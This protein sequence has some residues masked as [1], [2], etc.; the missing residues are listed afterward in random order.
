MAGVPF[1][2][3]LMDVERL[4]N[5]WSCAYCLSPVGSFTGG[6]RPVSATLDRIIPV[7][8][9]TRANTV[10]ACHQCNAAK[11]EHTP[12]SLRLWITRIESI[13]NRQNPNES[14]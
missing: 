12:E 11:A 9:Y 14:T 13:L 7:L 1:S 4:L 6:Q 3:S 8:G 10:L 5:N 2:L